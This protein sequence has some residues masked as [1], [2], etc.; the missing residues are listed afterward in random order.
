MEGE[1]RKV[2]NDN[3]SILVK[4]AKTVSV[5]AEHKENTSQRESIIKANDGGGS[6]ALMPVAVGC[7]RLNS[8]GGL[9]SYDACIVLG[10]GGNISENKAKTT[11]GG[12]DVEKKD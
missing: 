12:G 3:K 7:N 11:V 8:G 9:N 4:R 6:N 1:R 10:G 5:K 2:Q